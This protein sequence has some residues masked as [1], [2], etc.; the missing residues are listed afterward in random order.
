MELLAGASALRG[1]LLPGLGTTTR[2]DGLAGWDL[3]VEN[4]IEGYDQILNKSRS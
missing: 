1:V 2:R 4:T 3:I